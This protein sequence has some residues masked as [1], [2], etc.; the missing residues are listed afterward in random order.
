MPSAQATL[1]GAPTATGTAIWVEKGSHRVVVEHGGRKVE[2]S[3][4]AAAGE[5][6]RAVVLVLTSPK[7]ATASASAAVVPP[8][9]S[10]P[11]SPPKIGAYVAT[12]VALLGAGAFVYF[13]SSGKSD[14]RA[15]E[16]SCSPSCRDADVDP[17][18]RKFLFADVGLAAALLGGGIA[19]Y[20]FLKPTER[21]SVLVGP[22]RAELR[23]SF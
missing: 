4:D 20:L 9:P 6:G 23:L 21:T 3:F 19:T 10:E 16:S 18:R 15:L 7:P 14:Q 13:G 22:A 12:G 8:P 11:E 1:D 17:I 5:R 2:R